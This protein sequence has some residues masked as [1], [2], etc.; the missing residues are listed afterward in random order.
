MVKTSLL[1]ESHEIRGGRQILQYGVVM[2]LSVISQ[3]K[4]FVKSSP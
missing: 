1:K 4:G 2:V 3:K